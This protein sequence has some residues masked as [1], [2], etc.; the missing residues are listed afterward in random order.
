MVEVQRLRVNLGVVQLNEK[1]IKI[2]NLTYT[3]LYVCSLTSLVVRDES[4]QEPK[5]AD[6]SSFYDG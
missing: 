4:I 2:T 6:F 5:V 1:K 3:Y